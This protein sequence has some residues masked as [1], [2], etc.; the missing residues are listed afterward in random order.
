MSGAAQTDR[1]AGVPRRTGVDTFIGTCVGVYRS[2][3]VSRDR[4]AAHSSRCS[5]G[6]ARD[7]RGAAP[8]CPGHSGT[9]TQSWRARGHPPTHRWERAAWWE[10]TLR[11]C[12]RR[13]LTSEDVTAQLEVWELPARARSGWLLGLRQAAAASYSQG[14]AA[15]HTR[16]ARVWGAATV[17]T[18]LLHFRGRRW[19]P[20]PVPRPG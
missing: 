17:G 20:Q 7:R 19:T 8:D 6:R 15:G 13:K 3:W 10:G 5:Q 18:W 14:Q 12:G 4:T 2:L 1:E 16:R 9:A 11:H